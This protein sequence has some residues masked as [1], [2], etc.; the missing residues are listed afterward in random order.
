LYKH[1]LQRDASEQEIAAAAEIVG[2]PV[3]P[4]GVQDFLWALAMQPEF[5]LIY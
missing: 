1:A 4:E 3:T 2:N 5:Q